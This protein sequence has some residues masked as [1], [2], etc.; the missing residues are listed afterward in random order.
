MPCQFWYNKAWYN[1][2]GEYENTQTF[3]ASND[4]E[5]T[6]VY[7]SMCQRLI[8]ANTTICTGG[9]NDGFAAEAG[10]TEACTALSTPDLASVNKIDYPLPDNSTTLGLEYVNGDCSLTVGL[11]CDNTM[12]ATQYSVKILDQTGFPGSCK[13][14]T[15]LTN[16]ASCPV[17]STSQF[18]SWL[19]EYYYLWGTALI[20]IGFG[21]ALWGQQL[22]SVILFT[23]G[24]ASTCVLLWLLFYSTLLNEGTQ[25]WIGWLVLA[26][27]IVVGC[28]AGC[29]LCK[30]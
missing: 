15:E 9:G 14:Q 23:I 18:Y 2:I 21:V 5:G 7:F 26:G 1:L 12:T 22:F 16:K 10:S 19:N 11:L 24:G 13:Y 4:F 28:F 3:E 20:I 27:S 17:Y 8:N 30:C 25:L 6:K 29:T